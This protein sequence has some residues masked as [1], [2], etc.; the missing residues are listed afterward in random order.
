M[1]TKAKTNAVKM[2]YSL[3]DNKTGYFTK[4]RTITIKMDFIT[5]DYGSILFKSTFDKCEETAKTLIKD[6]FRPVRFT[7]IEKQTIPMSL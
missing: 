2:R 6:E 7:L 5:D 3:Y 4:Y 1:G